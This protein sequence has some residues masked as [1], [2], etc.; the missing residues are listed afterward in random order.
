MRASLGETA[1]FRTEA[2][3]KQPRIQKIFRRKDLI[4]Y[5]FIKIYSR[6]FTLCLR[7]KKCLL[8]FL[9]KW[10]ILLFAQIPYFC[11]QIV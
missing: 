4:K 10:Q 1:L 11:L 5:G 3:S 2:Q 7:A 6:L 9:K 8:E